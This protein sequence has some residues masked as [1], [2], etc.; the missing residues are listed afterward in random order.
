MV[1]KG[2]LWLKYEKKTKA[3]LLVKYA[4]GQGVL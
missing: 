2:G 3:W 1:M 4:Q